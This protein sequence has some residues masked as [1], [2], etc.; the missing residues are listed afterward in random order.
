[1]PGRAGSPLT[2]PLLSPLPTQ[3]ALPTSFRLPLSICPTKV[4]AECPSSLLYLPWLPIVVSFPCPLPPSLHLFN[5]ILMCFKLSNSATSGSIPLV[6]QW[7][8]QKDMQTLPDSWRQ[9]LGEPRAENSE[10]PKTFLE[11]H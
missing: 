1:M 7:G 9:V 10:E 6:R 11:M 3:L 4:S 2:P 8:K 5:N